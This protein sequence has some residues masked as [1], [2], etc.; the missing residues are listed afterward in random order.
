MGETTVIA[1]AIAVAL[2]LAP[3]PVRA[4]EPPGQ[5]DAAGAADVAG[6]GGGIWGLVWYLPNRVLDLLDPVRARVR[7]GP[8]GALGARATEGADFYLGSYVSVY[9]GLPGPRGGRLPR[10]PAG[11]ETRTG[12]EASLADLST[13]AGFAPEYGVG[14]L[15]LGVQLGLV[16]F[17]LGVDP[18]EVID[19]GLGIVGLD[20]MDDDF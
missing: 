18:L 5:A 20:P 11:L 15:G 3:A 12:A 2:V 4:S 9:V 7:L 6:A 19:L 14:E 13:G 1:V 10:L 16:G 17:D 8:G